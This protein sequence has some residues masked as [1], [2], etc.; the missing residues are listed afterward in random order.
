MRTPHHF[1]TL[2]YWNPPLRVIEEA[3]AS[4]CTSSR[5]HSAEVAREL[6]RVSVH[7]IERSE[8]RST[9]LDA[10]TSRPAVYATQR[11]ELARTSSI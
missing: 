5:D 7:I 3:A 10:I 9:E 11:T 8:Q 2:V 1:G 6:G 4:Q